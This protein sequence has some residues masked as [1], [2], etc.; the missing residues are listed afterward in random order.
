[1]IETFHHSRPETTANQRPSGDHPSRT[2]DNE[3]TGD[4]PFSDPVPRTRGHGL[5]RTSKTPKAVTEATAVPSGE[6]EAATQ[7]DLAGID[8]IDS[9]VTGR[10]CHKRTSRNPAV[11]SH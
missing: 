9:T 4:A 5:E 10:R 1:M 6:K 2:V 11:A 7:D 3:V 8:T